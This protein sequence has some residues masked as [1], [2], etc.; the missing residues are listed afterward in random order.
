M[1][2]CVSCMCVELEGAKRGCQIPLKL[3]LE[4]VMSVLTVGI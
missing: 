1:S 2:I 4:M 3:E